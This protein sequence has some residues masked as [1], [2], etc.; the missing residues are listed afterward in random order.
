MSTRA[1]SIPSTRPLRSLIRALRPHQWL[2]NAV[3]FA[4]LIFAKRFLDGD[5]VLDAALTFGLFCAVSSAVY[6]INDLLDVQADRR[7]PVKC[8]RPIASGEVSLPAAVVTAVALA[9]AALGG[10]WML[11][12]P[13]ALVLLVYLAM[14]V[15]YSL[16]LKRVVILD[17][18]VLA[19]GFLL[20]AVAGALVLDVEISSWLILCATLLS[21]FLGFCKRR[22]ELVILEE[23]AGEHR[24]ILREYSLPFLDQMISVVTSSTLVAYCFYTLSPEVQA[25]L[26]T[27]GLPWTIPLV[28]YGIFRYLYLVYHRSEGGS[29]TRVFYTDRPLLIDVA[30]WALT[31]ILVLGGRLGAAS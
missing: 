31:A 24:F 14:N 8:R 2:K 4:A 11:S 13:V 30:L 18:M 17:V 29:P 9:A 16:W 20:R 10:G 28:L 23:E 3:V 12:R 25:K 21:L 6:L 5:S 19:A 22:N 26:G 15:A 1:E 27:S 7:H